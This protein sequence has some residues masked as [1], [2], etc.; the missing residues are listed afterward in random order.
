[1]RDVKDAIPYEI[2]GTPG[3]RALQINPGGQIYHAYQ[4]FWQLQ[5]SGGRALRTEKYLFRTGNKQRERNKRFGVH[6]LS[7]QNTQ[8]TNS[9]KS[10]KRKLFG[11]QPLFVRRGFHAALLF[12][13]DIIMDIRSGMG[14]M[15]KC[16]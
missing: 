9:R 7:T 3:R 1:M 4:M 2:Y 10:T 16:T 12:M 6:I 8:K 14:L 13:S 5:I 15:L 11:F